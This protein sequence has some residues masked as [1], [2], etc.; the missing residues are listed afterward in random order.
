[1]DLGSRVPGP[2]DS[3]LVLSFI[4][5]NS[6]L[7][8]DSFLVTDL[9]LVTNYISCYRLFLVCQFIDDVETD[10]TR[11]SLCPILGRQPFLVEEG[12]SLIERTLF[13][14]SLPPE[15]PAIALV[16]AFPFPLNSS[17]IASND[18]LKRDT[19]TCVCKIVFGHF[20]SCQST[21]V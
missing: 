3:F 18:P 12:H 1:M 13:D 10:R 14:I 7:L 8:V 19:S 9:F 4:A 17:L 6:F 21:Y 15:D 2:V 11:C 5:L 20:H 16:S